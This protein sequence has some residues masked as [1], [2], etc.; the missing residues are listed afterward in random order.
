LL[1]TARCGLDGADP[2]G[3]LA[4]RILQ[5]RSAA[6]DGG[7]PA[8]LFRD[9]KPPAWAAAENSG[10]ATVAGKSEGLQPFTLRPDQA[11][12]QAVWASKAGQGAHPWDHRHQPA[13]MASGSLKT[14]TRSMRLAVAKTSTRVSTAPDIVRT[15]APGGHLLVAWKI[16]PESWRDS[17]SSTICFNAALAW[18]SGGTGDAVVTCCGHLATADPA[19]Y[20][21]AGDGRALEPISIRGQ[22]A[23]D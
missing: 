14:L 8:I 23:A 1:S 20:C 18:Q 2:A 22:D 9:A 21:V 7:W 6:E 11:I 4:T 17:R 5:D 19:G 15:S 10:P 16:A 13:W 3:G 12:E